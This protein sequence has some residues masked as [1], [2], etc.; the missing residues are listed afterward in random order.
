MIPG[1]KTDHVMNDL[2][3]QESSSSVEERLYTA[4]KES[5]VPVEQEADLPLADAHYSLDEGFN[6]GSFEDIDM[7]FGEYLDLS[8]PTNFWDPIFMEDGNT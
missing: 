8:L 3:M 5:V 4:S 7:L 1:Q 2:S 6:G